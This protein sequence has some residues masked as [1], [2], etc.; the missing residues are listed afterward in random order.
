MAPKPKSKTA[1][2]GVDTHDTNKRNI[3]ALF[4]GAAA[5][6][7]GESQ[8]ADPARGEASSSDAPPAAVPA[9]DEASSSAAAPALDVVGSTPPSTRRVRPRTADATDLQ[10]APACDPEFSALDAQSPAPSLTGRPEGVSPSPS[11]HAQ[12]MSTTPPDL[13]DVLDDLVSDT[14]SISHPPAQFRAAVEED[15]DSFPAGQSS[16]PIAAPSTK[17][18]I[19]DGQRPNPTQTFYSSR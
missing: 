5:K 13:L 16:P 3:L 6:R 12:L 2:A 15:G 11:K 10:D 9:P 8:A 14:E 17:S 19:A 4:G 1:K 18:G 7:A